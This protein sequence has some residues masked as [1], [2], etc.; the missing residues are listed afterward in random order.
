TIMKMVIIF[1]SSRL[2]TI[3]TRD[4]SSDLCSSDLSL[5][6]AQQENRV[7]PSEAERVAHHHTNIVFLRLV[8]NEVE[9][10]INGFVTV[11]RR[12][13]GPGQQRLY[14]G[15]R[16]HGSGCPDHV[17]RHGF[18]G[19]HRHP[20]RTISEKTVDQRHLC[21]VVQLCSCSMRIHTV[22]LLR[23]E[24]RVVQGLEHGSKRTRTFRMWSRQM[25]SVG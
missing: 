8:R 17:T 15:D 18:D 20:P 23:A 2:H 13:N 1:L 11:D 5:S 4:W 16:L 22:D 10:G 21:H 7:V 14:R 9:S 19:T 6:L 12:W 25:V 3:T 24:P